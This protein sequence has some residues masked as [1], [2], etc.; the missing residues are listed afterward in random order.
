M[1]VALTMARR[2]MG[3]TA[4]NPSVGCIIVDPGT[5]RIIGRGV[6]AKGGRPHAETQALKQAGGTAPGA[7]AYVTLEPCAHEGDTPS[8][9]R[10]LV[11][12]GVSRVIIATCD[13]DPRTAGRGADILLKAG[14]EVSEGICEHEAREQH[15]GFFSKLLRQRPTVTLKLATSLDGRIATHNGS[16]KWITGPEARRAGH[17]LRAEHDAILVG[18]N[19]ALA[20]DPDLTCRIAGLED[21]S[22][23]RV[24]ADGRLRLPLTSKL[25]TTAAT[26]PT[27]ILTGSAVGEEQVS[28]FEDTAAE[29]IQVPETAGNLLDMTKATEILSQRGITRL[30]VEGGSRLAASLLKDNLVDR[31]VWF[32]ASLLIGGDGK[33]A[34]EALGISDIAMST[35]LNLVGQELIGRDVTETYEIE[36]ATDQLFA[37]N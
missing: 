13:P 10:S 12:A 36:G 5:N 7:S 27:W 28:A 18:S 1:Q 23:V 17:L 11:G 33:S 8:C 21:C 16:S 3:M 19:T 26:T 20:D 25:V 35:R 2:H 29:L 22:P 30:L 24:V 37:L 34:L 6:T 31:L 15:L 14:I 32:R 4:P 9:A